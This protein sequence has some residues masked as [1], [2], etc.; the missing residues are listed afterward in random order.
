MVIRKS[1]TGTDKEHFPFGIF[2]VS[3]A[4]ANKKRR[5]TKNPQRLASFAVASR[6]NK[7]SRP[8]ENVQWSN[9]I[10]LNISQQEAF[11]C[12]RQ[13]GSARRLFFPSY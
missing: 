10:Q 9:G 2:H 5:R 12:L 8:L 3:F 7:C 11:K 13:V 4:I 6:V 1:G